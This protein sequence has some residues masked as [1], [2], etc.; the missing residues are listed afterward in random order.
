VP[1]P[2]GLEPGD[3]VVVGEVLVVVDGDVQLAVGGA[4]SKSA[5]TLCGIC[6]R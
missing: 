1:L 6:R 2:Q 3:V 4:R 5:F